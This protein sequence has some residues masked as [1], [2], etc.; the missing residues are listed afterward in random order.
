MPSLNISMDLCLN[1]FFSVLFTLSKSVEKAA[2]CGFGVTE[3]KKEILAIFYGI[4]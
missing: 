1:T 3:G 4:S 2:S